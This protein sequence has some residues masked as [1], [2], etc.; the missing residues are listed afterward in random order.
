[1]VENMFITLE[2]YRFAITRVFVSSFYLQKMIMACPVRGINQLFELLL[3]LLIRRYIMR[4]YSFLKF[5][6]KILMFHRSK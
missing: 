6:T 5:G 2:N 1:M 4:A 3:S